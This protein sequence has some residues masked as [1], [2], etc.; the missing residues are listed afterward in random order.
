MEHRW[1]ERRVVRGRV[2][3]G[4]PGGATT[5][6]ELHNL[7]LGGIGI[8]CGEPAAAGVR[9]QLSLRLEGL[10][11]IFQSGRLTGE[12]VHDTTGHVGI[13]FLDAGPETVRMLRAALGIAGRPVSH[14]GRAAA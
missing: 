7:S 4:F 2:R 8:A 13:A 5:E 9:V 12:V 3:V 1:S 14:P 10:A 6:T 11:D